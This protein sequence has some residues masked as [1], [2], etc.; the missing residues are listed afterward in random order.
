[1]KRKYQ[2]RDVEVDSDPA[3][4]RSDNAHATLSPETLK[5]KTK[6][7]CTRLLRRVRKMNL[8]PALNF[9]QAACGRFF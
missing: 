6:Y 5:T 9:T 2:R 1:M 3:M 7:S 8:L 4:K